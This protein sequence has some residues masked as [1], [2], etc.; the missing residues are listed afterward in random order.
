MPASNK[1]I[2][3]NRSV[4]GHRRNDRHRQTGKCKA[5]RERFFVKYGGERAYQRANYRRIQDEAGCHSR[6]QDFYQGYR[7]LKALETAE[8]VEVRDAEG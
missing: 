2:R 6:V 1:Y 8:T 7:I 4:K 3:Y 5:T